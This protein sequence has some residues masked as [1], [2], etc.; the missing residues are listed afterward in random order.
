MAAPQDATLASIV[1]FVTGLKAIPP[2]ALE[3]TRLRLID[4][5]ACGAAAVHTPLARKL[6]DG[7]LADPF[8]G[9][10]G[11]RG[12]SAY[13]VSSPT[14]PELAAFL[15][16]SLNRC[17]DFNDYG[18][19]GHPSDM[20]A[21]QIAF[22][23]S[24]GASGADLLRGVYVA[25][26][27]ATGIADAAPIARIKWDM[28]IY[29][30]LG[31]AAGFASILRLDADQTA[32]AVSLAVTPSIPLRV[33]R[34]HPPSD[35]RSLACA[36]AGMAAIFACRLARAG[37]SGPPAPF[38]GRNGIFDTVFERCVPRFG[39]PPFG[40]ER[41]SAKIYA[42]CGEGQSAVDAALRLSPRAPAADIE[43]VLIQSTPATWRY[44]GGGR[45]DRA[46]RW[47]PPSRE[48]ADH[49]LPYMVANIL[50]DGAITPSTYS[51]ER[52]ADR[53]WAPLIARIDTAADPALA[54]GELAELNPCRLTV[55]LADG[56]SLTEYSTFPYDRSGASVVTAADIGGK[57][58]Q[59]AGQALPPAGARALRDILAHLEEARDLAPLGALLR[60]FG[61]AAA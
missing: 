16:G 59:L 21:S 42:A 39:R 53:P 57:F 48:S 15:N 38:E 60:S 7:L 47:D 6:R 30:T 19:A 34:E 43:R 22:A 50:L 25:Y 8:I 40:V 32:N 37:V 58:D 14:S 35:W 20:I 23:E 29:D 54:E 18:P 44:L 52:L 27:V 36:Y 31:A 33:T 3:P 4:T 61:A 5:L 17:L 45:G 11:G 46:E 2:A 9:G 13:G 24:V 12:A 28:G 51:E 1:D 56:T 10:A 41:G 49:S 26:E 55:E